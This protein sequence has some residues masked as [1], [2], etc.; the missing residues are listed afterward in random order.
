MIRRFFHALL[1]VLGF[2]AVAA[3]LDH[4]CEV[5]AQRE[6]AQQRAAGGSDESNVAP[7]NTPSPGSAKWTR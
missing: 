7:I 4:A 6:L 2:L 5:L 1:I 3:D